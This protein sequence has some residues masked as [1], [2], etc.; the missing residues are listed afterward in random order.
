MDTNSKPRRKCKSIK[1]GKEFM[2]CVGTIQKLNNIS[3]DV[4]IML[5]EK[6]SDS[7]ETRQTVVKMSCDPN[8]WDSQDS[9]SVKED[10]ILDSVEQGE[11]KGDVSK[12]DFRSLPAEWQHKAVD[13]YQNSIKSKSEGS[14][15]G[16]E[17][18]PSEVNP[19]LKNFKCNMNN[20]KLDF[21]IKN[22]LN[23]LKFEKNICTTKDAA[24]IM[25][26]IKKYPT[27]IGNDKKMLDVENNEQGME[28]ELYQKERDKQDINMQMYERKRQQEQEN[29]KLKENCYAEMR[30][31][32]R[33]E[34]EG[35]VSSNNRSSKS[36]Q[37]KVNE[38]QI[39]NEQNMSMKQ[40]EPAI[41]SMKRHEVNEIKEDYGDSWQEMDK[42]E[43][44]D[45]H[46]ENEVP[47]KKSVEDCDNLKHVT[48]PGVVHLDKSEMY[49]PRRLQNLM[50]VIS[51][52][53]AE[54]KKERK[55]QKGQCGLV[56]KGRDV[57]ESDLCKYGTS[58]K[59][60]DEN[61]E[62]GTLCYFLARSI[63]QGPYD[64]R[65]ESCLG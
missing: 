51:Q 7:K 32:L 41:N 29:M 49:R 43:I 45:Q 62:A 63:R 26:Q 34:K 35:D 23:E 28:I 10:R 8:M 53:G 6:N 37:N 18:N 42:E 55:G 50:F 38:K 24:R 13:L 16:T 5:K 31:S 1:A 59:L 12:E 3:K 56:D 60:C 30:C 44:F 11:E 36:L 4:I 14:V 20:E 65:R 52:D 15:L 57:I 54:N 64:Q 48:P 47:D 40:K 61:E 58:S 19:G 21:E 39:K 17:T 2:S 27:I 25:A 33:R 46:F 9:E 22:K